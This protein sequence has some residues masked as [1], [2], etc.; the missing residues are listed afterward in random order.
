MLFRAGSLTVKI[1]EFK[2]TY[3]LVGYI[4]MIFTRH[5]FTNSRLHQ[6]TQRG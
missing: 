4:S 2:N 1:T 6:T 5:V 3:Q